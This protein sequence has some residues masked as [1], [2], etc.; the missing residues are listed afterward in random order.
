MN[1]GMENLT[2]FSVVGSLGEAVAAVADERYEDARGFIVEARGYI[3]DLCN[4]VDSRDEV[5]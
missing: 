1:E 4:A 2:K 5:R 3:D